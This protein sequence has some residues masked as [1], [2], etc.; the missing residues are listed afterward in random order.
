MTVDLYSNNHGKTLAE[1][2]Y[3]CVLLLKHNLYWHQWGLPAS[4]WGFIYLCFSTGI[5]KTD[6]RH[7]HKG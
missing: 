4:F 2:Q 1:M 3:Y 6:N 7:A 5:G